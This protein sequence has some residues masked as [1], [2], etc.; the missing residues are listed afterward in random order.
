MRIV[1][2]LDVPAFNLIEGYHLVVLQVVFRQQVLDEVARTRHCLLAHSEVVVEKELF[3]GLWT[4]R[5]LDYRLA[6]GVHHVDELGLV[7]Q[8]HLVE[9]FFQLLHV[10]LLNHYTASVVVESFP[11]FYYFVLFLNDDVD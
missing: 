7:L 2:A 6:L 3:V 8:I 4:K 11:E 1:D 5:L 9:K 10:K